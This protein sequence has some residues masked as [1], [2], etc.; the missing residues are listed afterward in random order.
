MNKE[1]IKEKIIAYETRVNG[2][3]GLSGVGVEVKNLRVTK[4][5]AVADII[6]HTDY[7]SG[8]SERYNKLEYLLDRL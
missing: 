2:F 7:E 3:E 8:T 1:T 4:I 5:K 6:L